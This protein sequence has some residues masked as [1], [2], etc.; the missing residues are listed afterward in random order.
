VYC[1]CT[2]QM[3]PN[4]KYKANRRYKDSVFRSIFNNNPTILELYNAIKGTNYKDESM[5]E[6][7]TLGDVL[8]TAIQNDLS[9][10]I[11]KKI[12]VLLEHQSTIN[13]NM[14]VRFLAY[15]LSI[16]LNILGDRLYRNPLVKL[17]RPEFIVLYNGKAPFPK[18]KTYRFIDVY[19][20]L[21]DAF[22]EI[23]NNDLKILDFT[24]RVININKGMNPELADVFYDILSYV[25]IETSCLAERKSKTLKGYAIF[26]AKVREYEKTKPLEE[27][28]K[29]AVKYCIKRG[30]L[31]DYFKANAQEAIKMM[32][33][34]YSFKDEL[35]AA[36]GEGREEGMEK[37]KKEGQ[38]YVMGLMAQGLSYEEIKKKLEKPSKKITRSKN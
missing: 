1:V 12:V 19:E 26:I 32:K 21:P 24:I 6:I 17:P 31:V 37:G 16:Y 2:K 36:R 5:I 3:K 28:I 25:G 35:R 20:E 14:H 7:N 10:G 33:F 29:L 9:F 27:A 18:E 13:E 30:I 11:D 23:D 8:F 22:E 15:I 34:E 4:K 38:N